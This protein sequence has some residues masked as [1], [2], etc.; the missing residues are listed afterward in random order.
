M[1]ERRHDSLCHGNTPHI[2]KW[3]WAFSSTAELLGYGITGRTD[4]SWSFCAYRE[5][6]AWS[7]DSWVWGGSAAAAPLALGRKGAASL[8]NTESQAW[9][10]W[11]LIE[12]PTS[13]L[14]SLYPLQA[15]AWSSFSLLTIRFTCSLG[16][17][18][19]LNFFPMETFSFVSW[20]LFTAP[21]A[22]WDPF[23]S[24]LLPP[25]TPPHR[26]P[27]PKPPC[28]FPGMIKAFLALHPGWQLRTTNYKEFIGLKSEWM[29]SHTLLFPT[30][31]KLFRVTFP[32]E[33]ESGRI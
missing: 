28:R 20:S 21:L 7:G 19:S 14:F 24:L 4:L 18:P 1:P 11:P 15:Q 6:R 29:F 33:S 3:V 31:A 10:R 22:P 25:S 17:V 12:V 30:S 32:K 23:L 27:S 5:H 9:A 16:Q 26:L 8:L 13:T 2:F